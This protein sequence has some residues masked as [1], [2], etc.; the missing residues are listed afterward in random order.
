MTPEEYDLIFSLVVVPGR[1]YRGDPDAVLRQFDTH[2][3]RGL[4]L[5]LLRAAIDANSAD[6]VEAS[7]IVCDTF[8]LDRE[9]VEP[10]SQ[11]VHADWHL[12]HENVV[13]LLGR[14]RCRDAVEALYHA[15][16]WVPDYLDYDETRALAVKALWALGDISDP[17]ARERLRQLSRSDNEIVRAEAEA[18][19]S[20]QPGP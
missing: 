4:G 17:V 9:H 20:R 3:G 7:L 1:S 15:A 19:L 12:Q 2:D 14:L 10:L 6:D 5:R 11:L 18:Q 16:T 13:T 8:G